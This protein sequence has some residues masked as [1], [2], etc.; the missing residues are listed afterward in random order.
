MLYPP[1]SLIVLPLNGDIL[2]YDILSLVLEHLNIF[3][4]YEW[5]FTNIAENVLSLYKQYPFHFIISNLAKQD[6]ICISYQCMPIV[7]KQNFY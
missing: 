7:P 2:L 5:I 6:I 3:A 4:L 1:W